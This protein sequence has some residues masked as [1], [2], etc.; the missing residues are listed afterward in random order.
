MFKPEIFKAYD[1]RGVYG[2]D[3]DDDL[4]YRLGRAYVELRQSDD[5]YIKSDRP[6]SSQPM[7]V[8]VG[9][10]MRLSSS[11][12]KNS[13][14]NGLIDAGANVI[15]VDLVSTPTF[16]F[17]VANYNYDGGLMISASHNPKEWNG[18]KVVR[19]KARPVSGDTGLQ[20]LLKKVTDNKFSLAASRGNLTVLNNVL[21][22]QINYDLKQAKANKIKPLKV[23]VDTANGMGALY[24]EKLFESIPAKLLP[25]NFDLDGS[26]PNHEA[27]PIKEENNKQLKTEVL[28]EKADL[29]IAV[30]GDGD[31]IFFVD[32]QG[33][34][35]DQAIIRG[36]LS[37][38]FLRDKPGAKI[39]YDIR[40]G[41]ITPDLI[42][43]NGGQAV[44]TK[45]GHA[46]IKEQMLKENI[47]FAGESSGHF[48]L[49]LAIGC[50]EMP[51]IM[52]LKLLEE[53]SSSGQTAADYIKPYKKYYSSGEINSDV[54]DKNLI[55]KNLA[56]KY[57]DAELN[58][59]DGLSVTYPDF[60]F[61]VRGSNTE[62]KIRL[63]LEATNSE[64]MKQK[65]A[66][67]LKIIRE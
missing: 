47:Y 39:G 13:L 7:R 66:E 60:W 4:A 15:D 52:I 16:Y 63:N 18:F 29:G 25:L 17:A 2:H 32:N 9:M 56:N 46:L 41:K 36:I 40:P 53:L 3:F 1:I 49:N 43:A 35:I 12:L 44:I 58:K 62:N 21:E 19:A 67:V 23:V 6:K 20:V 64:I 26:F 45:V 55:L 30:D 50:F 38:I 51:A 42:I 5:D 57:K 14:I 37:K 31:R 33:E 11:N 54:R 24:I 22:E 27:D 61:N 65:T 10:D 59:L 34:T 48:F 28:K 8:V